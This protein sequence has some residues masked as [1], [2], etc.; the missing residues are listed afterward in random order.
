[1]SLCGQSSRSAVT[2]SFNWVYAVGLSRGAPISEESRHPS[3]ALGADVL[4]VAENGCR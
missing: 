4:G 2:G 1:V 3:G